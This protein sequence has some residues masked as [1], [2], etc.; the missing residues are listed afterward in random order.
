MQRHTYDGAVTRWRVAGRYFEAC[1][2]EAICPCRRV[3]DR[4]GGRSTFGVCDF[5]LGWSIDEGHAGDVDLAGFEVVMAGSYDD[6]EPGSPWRVVLYV[7]ERAS[8]EQRQAIESI[9]LG[10]SGGSTL[11]NFAA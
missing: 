8:D 5:A 4:P 1:S 3:G 10:R 11:S 9:F 6:D 7:D 2:C